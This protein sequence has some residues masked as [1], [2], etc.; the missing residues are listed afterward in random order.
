MVRLAIMAVSTVVLLGCAEPE[1]KADDTI[2]HP[3]KG[4]CLDSD[5]TNNKDVT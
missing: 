2:F 5:T 4:L 3:V 1:R